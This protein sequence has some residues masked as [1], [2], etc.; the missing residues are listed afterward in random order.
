MFSS[1]CGIAALFFPAL[2]L[3]PRPDRSKMAEKPLR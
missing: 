2:V 1:A 3:A